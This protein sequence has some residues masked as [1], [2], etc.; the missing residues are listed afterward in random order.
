MADWLTRNSSCNHRLKIRSGGNLC[1]FPHEPISSRVRGRLW[2]KRIH[3][4]YLYAIQCERRVRFRS[5][6]RVRGRALYKHSLSQGKQSS[7]NKHDRA[8]LFL[9]NLRVLA[10]QLGTPFRYP[11]QV[12]ASYHFP[13]CVD[14]RSCLARTLLI[15]AI[16]SAYRYHI[17]YLPWVV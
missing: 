4:D 10:S 1:D 11:A 9:P 12:N 15:G 6:V 16:K 5:H 8:G 2:Y 13:T 14:L 3:T 7:N 17:L